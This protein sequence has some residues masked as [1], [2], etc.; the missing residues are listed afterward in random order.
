MLGLLIA[1]SAHGDR[2]VSLNLRCPDGVI[3][4][5]HLHVLGRPQP[6]DLVNAMPHGHSHEVLV[7][8]PLSQCKVFWAKLNVTTFQDH[9]YGGTLVQVYENGPQPNQ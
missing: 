9:L 5:A 3:T 1:N 8:E 2:R 4:C 7:G 6:H